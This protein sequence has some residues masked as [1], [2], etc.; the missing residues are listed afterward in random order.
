MNHITIVGVLAD[1]PTLQTNDAGEPVATATLLDWR[2]KKIG[3]GANEF[4][5]VAC[6]DRAVWFAKFCKEHTPLIVF[7]DVAVNRGKLTVSVQSAAYQS[8]IKNPKED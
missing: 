8:G 4:P 2:S 7:G 3:G 1:K 6:G 5:L